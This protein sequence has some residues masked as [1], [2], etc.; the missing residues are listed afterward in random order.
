M[1]TS[2]QKSP[3]LA[4][5]LQSAGAEAGS[6]LLLPHVRLIVNRYE[7]P[8][9]WSDEQPKLSERD[10]LEWCAGFSDRAAANLRSLQ[11]AEA[12]AKSKARHDRE[13]L[14]FVAAITG[15]PEHQREL[16][17]LLEKDAKERAVR[18]RHQRPTEA[19]RRRKHGTPTSRGFRRDRRKVASGQ[20]AAVVFWETSSDATR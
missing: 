10:L 11:L 19:G 20:R 17:A 2:I 14:E 8:F 3:S 9:N 6:F 1:T 16:Q 13:L 12:E 5:H 7:D 18:E 15:K 4:V